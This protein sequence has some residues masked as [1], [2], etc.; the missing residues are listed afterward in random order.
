MRAVY[1]NDG[2]L[3]EIES[4][5]S[6]MF[7]GVANAV[8]D[9]VRVIEH[10]SLPKGRIDDDIRADLLRW[11]SIR[12]DALVECHLHQHG[13]PACMSRIDVT[14]LADW[15]PHVRW[16]LG[17]RLYVALVLAE[18][19]IDGVAWTRSDNLAEPIETV[20]IGSARMRTTGRSIKRIQREEALHADR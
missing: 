9:G 11:A 16:R 2:A 13:D 7:F 4:S 5:A 10:T 18:T 8:K 6:R 17:G 15:A 1:L 19:T 14:G 12:G 20:Y 3:C